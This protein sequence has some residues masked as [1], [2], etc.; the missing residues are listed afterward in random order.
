ML[1]HLKAEKLQRISLNRVLKRG[2]LKEW[3][4]L[5]KLLIVTAIINIVLNYILITSLL[6]YGNLAAVFGVTVAI[7]TSNIFYLGGLIFIKKT[8]KFF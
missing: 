4:S 6:Q 8:E 5:A 1:G 2:C 3:G 7:I